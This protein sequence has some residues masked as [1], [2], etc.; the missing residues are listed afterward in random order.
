MKAFRYSS[1]ESGME[2]IDAPIPE[3]GPEHVQIQVKAA[4]MCHS[5]C[6]LLKGHYDAWIK[7]PLICG[8]EVAGIVT[9]VGS[10]VKDYHPSDR[11]ACLIIC[12]PVE[13]HDWNFAVGLGFDGGYAEYVSAPINRLIKIPDNVSFAQAAVAMDALATSYFAVMSKAGA[14]PGV[15]MGVIGLGGLGMAGL[16]F[17]IIAGAKVYGFDLQKHKLEEG[18]KLGA[19]GCFGS[20]EELKDV[21][22]DVIVDFAGVGVT[23]ASAVTAVKPG[24]TVVVVGLGNETMTLPTQNVVLKSVTVAGTL[25]SDLSATKGV[26]R[27]LEEKRIDPILKEIPFLDIPKGL[28]EIEK[29]EVVGRLWA[30][31]SK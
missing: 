21:T 6:H 12:Q 23:T 9:K 22:L 31:P 1:V 15:T 11:V 28:E 19:A 17:A 2:L 10:S 24:G 20:L 16:Q 7:I 18:L 25:G 8:H 4:G 27:L 29:E 5:D 13:E 30:D 14:N 3:P 26:L